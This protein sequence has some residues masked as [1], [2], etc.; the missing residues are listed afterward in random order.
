M[1]DLTL[2]FQLLP[3]VAT[4]APTLQQWGLSLT[5]LIHWEVLQLTPFV[6]TTYRHVS[7]LLD[8]LTQSI[9]GLENKGSLDPRAIGIPWPTSL[10]ACV[11]C[12]HWPAAEDV[13]TKLLQQIE[14]PQPERQGFLPSGMHA[15]MVIS[16]SMISTGGTHGDSRHCTDKHAHSCEQI[17]S[18][19]NSWQ[20]TF[21]HFSDNC[22]ARLY[23]G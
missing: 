1:F 12:K 21:D 23:N 3:R 9:S 5:L 8:S 13:A 20:D 17:S 7:F 4:L 16:S 2:S 11:Q 18:D 10:P 22:Q 14:A 15:Q 19:N 6:S